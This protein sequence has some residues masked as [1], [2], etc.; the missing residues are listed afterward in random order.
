MINVE[1]NNKLYNKKESHKICM[2]E[3]DNLEMH[4][5]DLW[6]PQEKLKK[7]L[8]ETTERCKDLD[9]SILDTKEKELIFLVVYHHLCLN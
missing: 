1:L 3:R 8:N 2:I 4:N 5:V 6:K 9:I 7:E